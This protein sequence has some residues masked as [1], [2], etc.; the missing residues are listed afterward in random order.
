MKKAKS[1]FAEHLRNKFLLTTKFHES[2]LNGSRRIVTKTE[3][4]DKRVKNIIPSTTRCV[5]V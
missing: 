4:T 1:I 3:L 5:G 2:L